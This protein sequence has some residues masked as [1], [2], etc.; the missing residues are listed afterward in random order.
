M[1]QFNSMRKLYYYYLLLITI[2]LNTLMVAKIEK[3]ENAACAV[4]DNYFNVRGSA[5][6]PWIS[7]LYWDCDYM[8]INYVVIHKNTC[9]LN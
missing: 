6:I 9:N 8:Q 1:E 2:E 5:G 4:Y 3:S 7:A